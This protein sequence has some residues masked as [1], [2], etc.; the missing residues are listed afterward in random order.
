MIFANTMPPRTDASPSDVGPDTGR[1]AGYAGSM[2]AYA[3]LAP[4]MSRSPHDQTQGG[5]AGTKLWDLPDSLLCPVIGT[6][7]TARELRR[8]AAKAGS[9]VAPGTTDYQMHVR[10]VSAARD[11]NALS[12]ETHKALRKRHAPTLRRYGEAKTPARL[13]EKWRQSLA[14][15]DVP[16]AFWATLTHPCSTEEIRDRAYEDVHMLSHQLGAGQRVELAE[17]AAVRDELSRLRLFSERAM[18]RSRRQIA[19]RDLRIRDLEA[20]LDESRHIRNVLSRRVEELGHRLQHEQR[21]GDPLRDR[22][23]AKLE[24]DRDRWKQYCKTARKRIRELESVNQRLLDE[25]ATLERL[26]TGRLGD[27]EGFED[28]SCTPQI[29]LGGRQLL[30]VG[31]RGQA[32]AHYRALVESCNGCFHH[33]DGGRE[34]NR[35]RLESMLAAVDT[36]FCATDCVSHDAC[37]RLKRFCKRH[38]KQH[39]F[40]PTSGLSSFARAIES[41]AVRVT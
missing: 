31:G 1:T 13:L 24:I 11:R 5:R 26:A 21:S 9:P 23:L 14:Q 25:H 3:T 33:H 4:A 39:V 40:L 36:V 6:C 22:L 41:V 20:S 32:V 19:R 37:L 12:L 15:G 2:S 7:L 29:D 34:D 17:L 18:E 16:G 28:T 8:I 38:A 30:Y 27:C 10:F 35:Q